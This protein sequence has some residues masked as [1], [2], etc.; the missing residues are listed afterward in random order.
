[1]RTVADILHGVASQQLAFDCPEGRP[2]SV[3]SVKI[4]PWDASDD[5]DTEWSP[6]AAVETNPNTTLDASAGPSQTNPR[7]IPLTA[8]TGIAIGRTYL[9]TNATTSLKEWVEVESVT[10]ADSVIARH[11]L[12]NDYAAPATFQSTRIT[13]T[14]DDTWAA[15]ETNIDDSAGANPMYRVRWVYVVGGVTYVADTYFNLTRY[16]ARHGV[17][18]QDIE[19]QYNGWL[20]SLPVDHRNDQG[21]K[22]IDEA[23]RA[24]KIDLHGIELDDARIA[25]AEVIDELVRYRTVE[26][27]E[28]SQFLNA[29][30]M[31]QT[32]H[33]AA[34]A[35]YTERLDQLI[36][37]A[38]KVPV[39]DGDGAASKTT[40]LGLSV[41]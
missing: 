18:P 33:L 5:S 38:M 31:D 21:R 24:V 32:R 30:N 6:T 14:V 28:W 19:A 3:T 26:R 16:G 1:M 4:L 10:S 36:R 34:K 8:T 15:D 27:F 37:I 17:T 2:S 13:A 7:N 11:P 29:R 20:D 41:R 23:Y 40:A 25:E 9:L 22:L 35:A 39:R 12:H